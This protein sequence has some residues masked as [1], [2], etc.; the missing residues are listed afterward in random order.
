LAKS[1]VS[2]EALRADDWFRQLGQGQA[3]Q[4]FGDIAIARLAWVIAAPTICSPTWT[5]QPK[6]WATGCRDGCLGTALGL[7][8]AVQA[9]HCPSVAMP[10]PGRGAA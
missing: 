10:R 3:S 6:W 2:G 1:H 8:I 4:C 9:R 7:L 5:L